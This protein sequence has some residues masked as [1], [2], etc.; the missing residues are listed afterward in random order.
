MLNWFSI[1]LSRVPFTKNYNEVVMFIKLLAALTPQ[2]DSKG[3]YSLLSS[4]WNS[5]YCVFNPFGTQPITASPY[6]LKTP[7]HDFRRPVVTNDLG[8]VSSRHNQELTHSI[9]GPPEKA[10]ATQGRDLWLK[11][12]VSQHF[13]SRLLVM[14][15]K[16]RILFTSN[17]SSWADL[18][19]CLTRV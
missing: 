3:N 17:V 19:R 7:V 2:H 8:L 16:L 10:A 1:K 12:T 15:W 14:S 18:E 13:S 5:Y 9:C 11:T 6:N 4:S